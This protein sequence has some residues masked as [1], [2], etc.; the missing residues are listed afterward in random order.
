MNIIIVGCGRVGAELAL[1]LS[2]EGH[3]ITVIDWKQESFQRL[4]GTF[5]GLCIVGSGFDLET[6]RKAGI[7]SADALAVVTNGDNTNIMAS[8]VAKTIFKVPR[9]IARLYDPKRAAIYKYMG[10]EIISGTVLVASM[11]RDKLIEKH[12]S[13]F[14]IEMRGMGVI[15]I[16]V[17]PQFAGKSV[18]QLNRPDEFLI[19]TIMK[20]GVAVIPSPDTTLEAGDTLIGIVRTG[21]LKAI[22]NMFNMED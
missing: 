15:Q 18:A 21:S 16:A 12:F 3:N 1:L 5:N 20:K 8:Q 7:E 10:L 9:V 4:G 2:Y 17:T 14:F 13:D 22:K 19:A 11:I 6:L